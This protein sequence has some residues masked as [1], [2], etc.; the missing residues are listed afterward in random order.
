MAIKTYRPTSPARRFYT[1][2]SFDEVT[3]KEPE[4]SLLVEKKKHAGSL[5]L[6]EGG[7]R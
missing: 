6:I 4:K 3:K 7:F 5:L 2:A 1:T